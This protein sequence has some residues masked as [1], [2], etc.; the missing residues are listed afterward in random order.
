MAAT[1]LLVNNSNQ[2]GRPEN[3]FKRYILLLIY[4]FNIHCQQ[5]FYFIAHINCPNSRG[6]PKL[7]INCVFDQNFQI[8]LRSGGKFTKPVDHVCVC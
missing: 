1:K 6:P 7:L 4:W 8:M 3:T 5:N 2:N